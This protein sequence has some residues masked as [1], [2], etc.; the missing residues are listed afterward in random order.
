MKNGEDFCV[1]VNDFAMA[2]LK[3]RVIDTKGHPELVFHW[4]GQRIKQVVTKTWREAQAKHGTEKVLMHAMRHTGASWLVSRGVNEASIAWLGG[5][6]LPS[7]LGAMKR[8][9]H[10]HVGRLRPITAML[11]EELE[12]GARQLAGEKPSRL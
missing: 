8:Y 11:A 7:H 12:E 4:R 3:R 2:I 6:R 10:A 9:L 1:P 5:W